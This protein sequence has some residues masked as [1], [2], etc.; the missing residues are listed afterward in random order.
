MLNDLWTQ[1]IAWSGTLVA[2]DWAALVASIPL[3]LLLVLATF[4]AITGTKWAAVEPSRVGG[5]RAPLTPDG[6]PF[7]SPAVAPLLLA[8]GVFLLAFGML[9]GMAWLVAGAITTAV[10]LAAWA[11]QLRDTPRPGLPRISRAR[12]GGLA[13]VGLLAAVLVATAKVE[14]DLPGNAANIAAPGSSAASSTLPAA[15]ATLTARSVVFVES[16]LTAPAGRP[17]TVAFDNRDSVPHN[18]EIRDANGSV[19]F[20]GDFVTGPVIKVYDVPTL[21]AGVYPFICTIHPAMKG[22]LTVK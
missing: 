12:L 18:L 8:G 19:V 16:A 9:A 21:P 7:Q 20:R 3:L 1:L 22:T 4:I 2:P 15:D 5:P 14:P 11:V 6:R 10:A 17:F 13:G